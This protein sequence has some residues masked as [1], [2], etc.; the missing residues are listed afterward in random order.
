MPDKQRHGDAEPGRGRRWKLKPGEL[1]EAFM[2]V[3][4]LAEDLS[5]LREW[6]KG[7]GQVISYAKRGLNRYE[8]QKD[9]PE[10]FP[11]RE[12]AQNGR[13]VVNKYPSNQDS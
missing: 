4:N 2:R 13:V 3:F 9:F 5:R 10:D 8:W 12:T 11:G 7:S 1:H 6:E